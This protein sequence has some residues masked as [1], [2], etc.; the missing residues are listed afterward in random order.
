MSQARLIN[1]K[2]V[3]AIMNAR[4]LV[5]LSMV[6]RTVSLSVQ[7][8]GNIV[9]VKNAAGEL[10]QSA[11]EEGTVF[12][13]HIFNCKANSELAMKNIRNIAILKAGIAA[14]KA[15]N[16]EEANKQFSDYLNKVQLS[17]NVP[18][19]QSI[20][21]Q[22]GNGTDIAAKV[23]KVDTEKGSLLTIDPKTIRVMEPELLAATSFSFDDEDLDD[24]E[25]TVTTEEVLA[26]AKAKAKLTA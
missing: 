24:E 9:D 11:V 12:Q 17:F 16:F 13:K 14:E 26:P 10:V 7:G 3:A 25:P 19:T 15:G 22:I 5:P 20:A 21:S 18:T 8:N 1:M 23:M 6:G 4:I 2:A